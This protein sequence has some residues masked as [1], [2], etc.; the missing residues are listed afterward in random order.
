MMNDR[1]EIEKGESQKNKRI[2]TTR[3]NYISVFF[4]FRH[5]FHIFAVISKYLF[6]F[7]FAE[8][9]WYRLD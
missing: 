3:N 1:R 4:L 8:L 7:P 2:L 6:S 5:S 9:D